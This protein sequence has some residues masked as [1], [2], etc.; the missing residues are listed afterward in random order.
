M[1]Q[2]AA[3]PLIRVKPCGDRLGH[4]RRDHP[5]HHAARLLVARP[6]DRATRSAWSRRSPPIYIG[7]AVS[8]GRDRR[9][10]SSRV[11]VASL[12]VLARR[13]RDHRHAV[14]ARRRASSATASRT[15]GSTAPTSS[16]NTRWWPPFCLTVDW[17]LAAVHRRRDRGWLAL[18]VDPGAGG[19]NM[20]GS[21]RRQC[22]RVISSVAGQNP[23]RG[24]AAHSSRLSQDRGIPNRLSSGYTS[25]RSARRTSST[26]VA[27]H[28]RVVNA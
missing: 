5:G 24:T 26:S 15:C 3:R 18:P 17:P 20:P 1:S 7:F 11:G 4:R 8:D 16:A 27:I 25:T 6:L 14:A 21:I 13:P 10:S 2:L 23:A 28:H 19:R 9:S 12:V 22:L